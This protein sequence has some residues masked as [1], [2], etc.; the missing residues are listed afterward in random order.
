MRHSELYVRAKSIT[1]D[2]EINWPDVK[3]ADFNPPT[4][5]F[6]NVKQSKQESANEFYDDTPERLY[7]FSAVCSSGQTLYY[8]IFREYTG[9]SNTV[10]LCTPEMMVMVITK[11][12]KGI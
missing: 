10:Y 6:A 4:Q 5:E 2:I 12:Q 7:D 3:V 8:Y 11:S 1:G 9:S